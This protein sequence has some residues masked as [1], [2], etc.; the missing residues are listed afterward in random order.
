[1][2]ATLCLLGVVV[3]CLL[4]S[5]FALAQGVAS[6]DIRVIVRDPKGSVVTNATV[7]VSN[8]A[9]GLERSGTSDGQGGYSVRQLPPGTYLVTVAAAGSRRRRTAMLRSR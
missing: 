6:G 2:R 8:T 9:K 7:T 3:M 1:M 5:P 4:V